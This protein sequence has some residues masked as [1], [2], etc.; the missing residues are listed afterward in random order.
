MKTLFVDAFTFDAITPGNR[1]ASPSV[2]PVSDSCVIHRTGA[3]E[4]LPVALAELEIHRLDVS[5]IL[6]YSGQIPKTV[7]DYVLPW[8]SELHTTP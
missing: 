3:Q 6:R 4:G 2:G 8:L 7:R 5:K 1:L